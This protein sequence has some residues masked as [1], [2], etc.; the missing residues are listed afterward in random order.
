MPVTFFE[1]ELGVNVVLLDGDV[2]EELEIGT[3]FTVMVVPEGIFLVRFL[4]A[5]IPDIPDEGFNVVDVVAEDA[6]DRRLSPTF[7]VIVV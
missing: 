5:T 2:D 3:C 7:F 1:A 6:T 4:L